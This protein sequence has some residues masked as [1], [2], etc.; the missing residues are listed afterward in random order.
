MD[1][2]IKNAV[3]LIEDEIK[4][5]VNSLEHIDVNVMEKQKQI[6]VLEETINNLYKI[7]MQNHATGPQREKYR[8]EKEVEE[9]S[10]ADQDLKDLTCLYERLK[11]LTKALKE[12]L[13]SPHGSR[14]KKGEITPQ[15]VYY[16]YILEA[17]IEMDGIG[18]S[19]DVVKNV[20]KKVRD[21]LTAKDKVKLP[22][23]K[24]IT[25][26]NKIN[27][28]RHDLVHDLGYMKTD[29]PKGL[30]EISDAGREYYQQWKDGKYE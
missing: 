24:A 26:V 28:A 23:N 8:L 19:K 20:G 14:A 11:P 17:L 10:Q 16:P 29:S 9:Y 6:E 22:S 15:E 18:R 13:K 3:D 27:W 25:W 12:T 1:N 2:K 7:G 5:M 4:S 21:I 30:W